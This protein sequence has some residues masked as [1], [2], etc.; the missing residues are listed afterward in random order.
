MIKFG[1]G[2]WRA[3]IGDDFTR[4]NLEII[5]QA[6]SGMLDETGIVIGYDRRFLS[7]TA[8]IWAAEVFAGNNKKVLFIDKIAPTP[9]IMFAVETAGIS[10]GMAVTA[11]HNPAS[12]NGIKLFNN[13]GRDVDVDFTE[14]LES[15]ILEVKEIKRME[16]EQAKE[17]GL[18]EIINPMNEYVDAII[19]KID[20]QK[21][22]EANLEIV[23]DPMF[24][25]SRTALLAVLITARCNVAIINDRRDALFGGRLPAPEAA[26]LHK[27][28]DVV[29]ANN[30][31]LGIATD[32][33]ADRIGIIDD[34]GSFIHPN[35]LL[36]ILYYY[37][38]KY[39]GWEG[40]AVRNVATTHLLD[41]IAEEFG[42]KCHEAPVGFKNISSAMDATNAI[43]GGE[44]SG[45]LTIRGHIHGKDGIFAAALLVEIMA[46]S[47]KNLRAF[48]QEIEERYGAKIWIEKS[49]HFHASLKQQ[50]HDTLYLDKK[51]PEF[52]ET[53]KQ[54]KYDD[55]I[56]VYF[57]NGDWVIARFS[58]TEPLLR[59][60]SES[61]SKEKA[62]SYVEQFKTMLNL[63]ES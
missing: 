19:E 4:A 51:I 34:E 59:I 10:Y 42:C 60:F 33:D 28:I 9:L 52:S 36:S 53:V 27:L 56:K 41:Q 47:G 29:K 2:G 62:E 1:T 44:S 32:G 48:V 8:A 24:G 49:L 13:G 37:F 57:E 17:K 26:T 11:S 46:V 22:R 14:V 54:V 45:G 43:I 35:M 16:F 38:L 15:R 39:K 6:M 63:Q 25:V 23:I 5:C 50:L 3:I 7:D 40:D 20:T 61:Q 12:Y 30:Y 31:D 55:G 21:I 58:G 18:V